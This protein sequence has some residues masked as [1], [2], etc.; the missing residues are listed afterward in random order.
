MN[1]EKI[2]E[3]LVR[4]RKE[5]GL[6]A[7]SVAKLLDV[8]DSKYIAWEMGLE[9]PGAEDI[10]KIADV[11]NID[12]TALFEE[13]QVDTPSNDY[14]AQANTQRVK[15]KKPSNGYTTFQLWGAIVSMVLCGLLFVGYVLPYINFWGWTAC[16]YD[17][18]SG[19]S[20]MVAS[21][22]FMLL[23]PIFFI[24]DYIVKLS[25]KNS[26][27]NAYGKVSNIIKFV[28]IGVFMIMYIILNIDISSGD[29]MDW[30]FFVVLFLTI[31]FVFFSIF[32]P[33]IDLARKGGKKNK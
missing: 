10:M 5:K 9:T 7:K 8:D 25:Y 14:R 1:K 32:L 27:T 2:A 15:E 19:N 31:A 17:C 29:Y 21:I 23:I 13:K 3:N 4:I 22:V 20:L 18:F 16:I 6:A 24:I 28:L 33:C 26:R 30:G 11:Y 12:Y